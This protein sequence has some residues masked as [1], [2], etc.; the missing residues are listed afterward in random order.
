MIVTEI[1][2]YFEAAALLGALLQPPE[3]QYPLAVRCSTASERALQW[4]NQRLS[5]KL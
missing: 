1:I 5:T 3:L 4:L 2:S